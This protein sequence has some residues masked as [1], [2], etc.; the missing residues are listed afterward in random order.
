MQTV[1]LHQASSDIDRLK[2]DLDEF[3]Y[4][5]V[6]GALSL[7]QSGQIRERLTEQ[8]S[9]ERKLGFEIADHVYDVKQT[10]VDHGPN[11]WVY[12]LVNKGDEF[13][14][15]LDQPLVR[16]LI[17]HALGREYIL[18]DLTAHITH[19][20]NSDMTL[21]TDQWWMPPPMIPGEAD[22]IRCGDLSRDYSGTQ[23]TPEP[24]KH[25][26]LPPFQIN[27]IWMLCDFS[28]ENGATRFVPGSHLSGHQ[29][30]PEIDYKAVP[31]PGSEG[32]AIVWD[33]R[34]WHAA[35]AN[36]SN[37]PRYA[38]GTPCK[39]PQLRQRVNFP[40]GTRADVL[41]RLSEEEKRLLGFKSWHGVGNTDDPRSEVMRPAEETMG[42]LYEDE[43][44]ALEKFWH[45]AC[46]ATGI[47]RQARYSTRR[48]GDPKLA[49][50]DLVDGLVAAVKQ[51]KKRGTA[52]CRLSLE[53]TGLD[54]PEPGEYWIVL[55]SRSEP[56]C[57]VE[58]TKVEHRRFDEVGDEW[59]A[60]EGEA[61]GSFE[62]W[63]WMHRWYYGKVY[64][65]WGAEFS[66]DIPVVL[67]SFNLVYTP[68]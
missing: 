68:S 33:G 14:I 17:T 13:R 3:G 62:Y 43:P 65:H 67:I 60:R 29:P 30:D 5:V 28:V 53:K 31:V 66:D 16:S 20:G 25:P 10:S 54:I 57:M 49:G 56:S 63:H 46:T 32:S 27:V 40:Y 18:S 37:A 11:Q 59:A 23:G 22:Y 55:N 19:P 1:D 34:I 52:P 42:A 26:I 41:A 39:G 9:L 2:A 58:V 36:T 4:A 38:L 15:T 51:G 61:D 47:D 8:A 7:E 24:S 50:E 45:Q 6:A 44:C 12:G 35:G 21:H 64:R 48:F